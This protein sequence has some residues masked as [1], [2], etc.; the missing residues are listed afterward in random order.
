MRYTTTNPM[1]KAMMTAI[2]NTAFMTVVAKPVG[3]RTSY[4]FF[5]VTCVV[6]D[7]CVV[8]PG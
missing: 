1:M 2:E 3:V 6:C 7:V 5:P 8:R 4:D